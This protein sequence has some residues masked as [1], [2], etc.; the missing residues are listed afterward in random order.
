MADTY[1]GAC[2]KRPTQSWVLSTDHVSCSLTST[3]R[4]GGSSVTLNIHCQ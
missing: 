1:W 4:P 3:K 2:Y